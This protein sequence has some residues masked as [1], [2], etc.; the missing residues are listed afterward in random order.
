MNKRKYLNIPLILGLAFFFMWGCTDDEPTFPERDLTGNAKN[1][2]SI[3][4]IQTQG[5]TTGE[6]K[7]VNVYLPY[8]YDP[9]ADPAYPVVYLLHGF[10]GDADTWLGMQ[11]DKVLD[12]M[13]AEGTIPPMVVVMPDASNPLGGSFYTNS[14]DIDPARNPGMNPALGF[15]AYEFFIIQE[16]IATIEQGFNV[17]PAKRGI[18]GHSMGGYGAMKL[19]MLYPTMFKSVASHS[20]P[21]SFHELLFNANSNLM[22]RLAMENVDAAGNPLAVID[23]TLASASPTTHPLT[24]TMFGMASAFAPHFGTAA[25]YDALNGTALPADINEFPVSTE[26]V[27]PDTGILPGVDLPVRIAQ[28]GVTADTVATVWPKFLAHDCYTMLATGKKYDQTDLAVDAIK[29]LHIYI[30]CGDTDDFDPMDDGAGFGI[31]YTTNAF[32][33]LLTSQGVEHMYEVY[34]GAHSSDVYYRIEV[35]FKEHAKAL[36]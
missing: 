30:D 6:A 28:P 14:V 18:A 3:Q 29:N 17:D 31:I 1:T 16:L 23:L 11:V 20:G 26:E 5:A 35:A 12:V 9:N 19:A 27:V 10:G 8:G 4:S 13:I 22:P 2:G 36:Q 21:L 25:T 7:D 33:N 15:G 24:L 32:S 34:S